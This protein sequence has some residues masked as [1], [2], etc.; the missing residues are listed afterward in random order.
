VASAGG[1]ISFAQ[2]EVQPGATL[3]FRKFSTLHRK[4]SGLQA[5]R[6][7]FGAF[8]SE[9]GSSCSEKEQKTRLFDDLR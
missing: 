9:I 5:N 7:R 6:L 8:A 2:Q 1:K 3:L 4:K